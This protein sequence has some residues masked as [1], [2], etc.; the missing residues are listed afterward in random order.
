MVD[1]MWYV[2][3]K[4]VS[5]NNFLTKV[6][7]MTLKFDLIKT[8][9]TGSLQRLISTW[10]MKALWYIIYKIISRNHYLQKWPSDRGLWPIKLKV[11]RSY[12][13]AKTNHHSEIWKLC[14]LVVLVM[15]GNSLNI[16][17][18]VTSVTLTFDL[19]NSNIIYLPRPINIWKINA[20]W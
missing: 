2:V 11:K 13:L 8:M 20:F 4:I 6:T 5:E 16:F 7:N 19:V 14:L 12:V 18:K 3:L 15:S 17:T 9:S 1:L 10:N